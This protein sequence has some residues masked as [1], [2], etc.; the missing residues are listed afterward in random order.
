MLAGIGFLAVLTARIASRFVK[1]ERSEETS[2]ITDG[3]GRIEAD[4]AALKAQFDA[5]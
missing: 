2:A 4:L 1:E 3:L 5:R